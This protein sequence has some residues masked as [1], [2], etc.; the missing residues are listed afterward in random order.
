MGA[1]P[2]LT[3]TQ[4]FRARNEINIFRMNWRIMKNKEISKMLFLI[5]FSDIRIEGRFRTPNVFFLFHSTRNF[6]FLAT[7]SQEKNYWASRN[8]STPRTERGG[9]DGREEARRM[10]LHAESDKLKQG[11]DEF[12]KWF[13]N[14]APRLYL[15]CALITFSSLL[16][17]FP[18]DPLPTKSIAK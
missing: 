6:A 16:R 5:E 3:L 18:Q 11:Q 17:L 9:K 14:F 1:F 2:T 12:M 7:F 4:F 8:F 10:S 15:P 13:I